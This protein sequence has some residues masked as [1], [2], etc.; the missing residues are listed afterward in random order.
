M[1]QAAERLL[2]KPL[3]AQP[4]DLYLDYSRTGN[5]KPWERVAT[6][7]RRRIKIFVLAECV[8]NQGRFVPALEE[9]AR[10]LCAE[11]TWVFPAHDSQLVNYR[12]ERI[13]IDLGSARVAGE[14][15]LACYLLGDRLSKDTRDLVVATVRA[16][17]L[18]P[19]RE[20]V[21]GRRKPNWWLAGTNNWNSVCLAGVAVSAVSLV[22][23]RSERAFFIAAAEQYVRNFLRGFTPD[24]YCSEGLAYWNYGFGHYAQ[25]SAAL[26]QSTQGRLDLLA[27]DAA[28]RPARFGSRVEIV[29]GVYPTFSDCPMNTRPDGRLV[30]YLNRRLGIGQPA[31]S[32]DVPSP[33]RGGLADV[34][35]FT[36]WD[37]V[38]RSGPSVRA[39]AASHQRTWFEDA[40]VLI[41]RPGEGVR[42]RFGVA[43]K[44]GH[45]AE[46]HNH[47]DIGS[48]IVV[49]GDRPVL[50][51]PGT[52][53]YTA[54]T[55]SA[56]RY[57]SKV[58]NSFGHSVPVV[59][60]TLQRGG[61]DARGRVLEREFTDTR[62]TLVLDLRTAYDAPDLER[63]ERAF[64]YERG[65]G[66]RLVVTDT[67]AFARPQRFETALVTFG[68]WRR[69]APDQ[70]RVEDQGRAVEIVVET[71]GSAFT[72]D[73]EMIDE[74]VRSPRKPRRIAIRLAQPTRAAQVT[75]RIRPAA[76][77]NAP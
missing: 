47:N 57:E 27:A 62:D 9:H 56:R 42:G 5:R 38:P 59:A 69:I 77:G 72:V 44:G 16:R 6:A 36:P 34:L 73:A 3:P 43:L 53:V 22:E 52:E 15:A 41:C 55:F 18:G 64:C 48:F 67:I 8:E 24:G 39:A 1:V 40:G 13:D 30:G 65:Q 29:G 32:R 2:D 25:L 61:E 4:A 11:P 50:V 12:G 70:L 14:L 66:G 28:L 76:A 75:L 51:D 33:E 7:R 10:R 20:M 71:G 60:G 26:D 35:A 63:L 37:T 74:N 54:R 21:L 23:D 68:A 45:N 19:F 31:G 17:V 46:H 58:L 49:V